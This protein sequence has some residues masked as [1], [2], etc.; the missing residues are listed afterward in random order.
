MP[1]FP[2]PAEHG[3]RTN[4]WG[5]KQSFGLVRSVCLFICMTRANLILNPY[6]RQKQRSVNGYSRPWSMHKPNCSY[7]KAEVST[8]KHRPCSIAVKFDPIWLFDSPKDK[9]DSQRRH[10]SPSPLRCIDYRDLSSNHRSSILHCHFHPWWALHHG[11]FLPCQSPGFRRTR[12][13]QCPV[14]RV[15]TV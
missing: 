2:G 11:G 14:S 3:R 10:W 12:S 8:Q 1:V 13:Q 15:T 9:Y 6:I 5:E 7:T 4:S